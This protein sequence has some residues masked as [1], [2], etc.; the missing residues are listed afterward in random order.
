[1]RVHSYPLNWVTDEALWSNICNLQYRIEQLAEVLGIAVALWAIV[2][3]IRW[4]TKR[5]QALR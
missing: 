2:D 1:M 4:L 5:F 3:S